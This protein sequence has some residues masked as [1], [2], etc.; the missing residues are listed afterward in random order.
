MFRFQLILFENSVF[1]ILHTTI[2]PLCNATSSKI[3]ANN[4]EALTFPEMV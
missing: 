3:L 1:F 2:N 4:F